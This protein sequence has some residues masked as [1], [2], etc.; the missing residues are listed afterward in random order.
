MTFLWYEKETGPDNYPR[1]ELPLWMTTKLPDG[2]LEEEQPRGAQTAP[3]GA[4]E[5]GVK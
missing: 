1:E 4:L 2:F 3:S 5:K